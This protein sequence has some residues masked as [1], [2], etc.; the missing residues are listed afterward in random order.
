MLHND[1][2]LLMINH[3][4]VFNGLTP[5]V[6]N[7]TNGNFLLQTKLNKEKLRQNLEN[8]YSVGFK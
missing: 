7:G 2:H 8:D 4:K 3:L 6:I 5:E 1:V